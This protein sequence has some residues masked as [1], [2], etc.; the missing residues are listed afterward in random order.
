MRGIQIQ[1]RRF[2]GDISANAQFLLLEDKSWW[3]GI[4]VGLE[5]VGGGA[6]FFRSGY[7]TLSKSLFGRVRG[8]FGFGTG[9]DVL[10]G[11]FAGVELALNRFV[12]LLGEY[13]ADA[14]NAG[15]RLF[16]LPE[17]W[18]SYGI[19]RPTVDVIWQE[20]GHVSWGI[21]FRSV[22]GEAKYQA[23]REARAG[24]R[25]SRQSAALFADNI[26]ADSQ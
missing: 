23:Q 21:S 17:K 19:P 7:V 24:K 1:G 3:P 5:D 20:G 10:K 6:T 16:P 14:F 11:P 13:D 25:Y 4:A 15:V 22:L 12:T 26:S 2:A 8:T 18:E 9:P